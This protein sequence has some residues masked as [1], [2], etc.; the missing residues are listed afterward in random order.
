MKLTWNPALL[1]GGHLRRLGAVLTTAR[2]KHSS[3]PF[4]PKLSLQNGTYWQLLRWLICFDI[5]GYGRSLLSR[6]RFSLAI[7][8]SV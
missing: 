8:G 6:Y 1:N 2:P 5:S 7:E 4:L 3:E